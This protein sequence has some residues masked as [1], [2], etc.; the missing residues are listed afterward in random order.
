MRVLVID[1]QPH[2]RDALYFLLSQQPDIECIGVV[3]AGPGAASKLALVAP[4]VVVLDW[5][6]PQQT[7]AS[8]LA[9]AGR[10]PDPPRIVVLSSSPEAEQ[11]ALAAGAAAFV[12]KT[13]PP[14][15]VLLA[16]RSVYLVDSK[17]GAPDAPQT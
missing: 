8:L 9:I 10:L 13:D 17:P 2:V 12:S 7:A 4:E 14:A 11:S 1:S 5:D 15:A 6:L 16:L 3:G